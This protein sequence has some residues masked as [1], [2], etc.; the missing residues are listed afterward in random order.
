MDIWDKTSEDLC[1]PISSL[2]HKKLREGHIW[3]H[4]F[5]HIACFCVANKNYM[6]IHKIYRRTDTVLPLAW[7]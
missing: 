1:S 7:Q 4:M 6:D 2:I 3:A 5:W